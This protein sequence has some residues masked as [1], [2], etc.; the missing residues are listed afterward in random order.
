MP[1][2][3]IH[4]SRLSAFSL[5]EL[6]VVVSIIAV[7]AAMLL[8][9]VSAMKR[10]AQTTVCASN[11]RQ[12]GLGLAAYLADNENLMPPARI[13]PPETAVYGLAAA[14]GAIY[15]HSEPLVGGYT[16]HDG[17]NGLGKGKKVLHCPLGRPSWNGYNLSYGLN[18]YFT[19]NISTATGWKNSYNAARIRSKSATAIVVESEDPRFHPGYGNPPPANGNDVGTGTFSVGI[20]QPFCAY[21]WVRRHGTGCNVL[22]ADGHLAYIPDPHQEVQAGAVLMR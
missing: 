4:P 21:N 1:R 7:L 22:F 15:W 8:P 2:R 5:I 17:L 19:T 13:D 20:G 10:L 16:G 9:A 14:Y 18:M 6:L 12:V 11:L 3:H